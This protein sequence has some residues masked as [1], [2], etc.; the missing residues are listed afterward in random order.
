MKPEERIKFIIE[1]LGSGMVGGP[2][3]VEMASAG[4]KLTARKMPY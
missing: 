1:E 4:R 3:I 2:D